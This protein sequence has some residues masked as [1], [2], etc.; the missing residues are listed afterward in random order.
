MASDGSDDA[1]SESTGSDAPSTRFLRIQAL[2]LALAGTT[3]LDDVLDV[4]VDR[5]IAAVGAR[6]GLVLL[7]AD[8]TGRLEI[9]RSTGY[10]DAI[11]PGYSVGIPRENLPPWR[12]IDTDRP[13]V[14]RVA[15]DADHYPEICATESGLGHATL[16]SVPVT[17]GSTPLGALCLSFDDSV[18]IT[19]SEVEL[20]EA[21][22]RHCGAAVERSSLLAAE[23]EAREALDAARDQAEVARDRLAFLVQV[24]RTVLG[25]LD[26]TE[27]LERVLRHAVPRIADAG[28]ALLPTR[29]GLERVAV[30]HGNPDVEA[31]G[32]EYLLGTVVGFDAD[33]PTAQCFRTGEV[34]IHRDLGDGATSQAPTSDVPRRD[35]PAGLQ[36]GLIQN[37]LTNWLCV[38]IRTSSDTL[39]VLA[40]A[41]T[42]RDPLDDPEHIDLTVE[43][44]SRAAAGLVNATLYETQRGVASA[45]TTSVL[46]AVLPSVDGLDLAARYLPSGADVGGDWYDALVLEDGRVALTIGDVSGHGLSSGATMGQLRNAVR[47]YVLDGHDPAAVLERLNRLLL[48]TSHDHV[49]SVVH[50]VVDPATGAIGWAA[51]GHPP[52][53]VVDGDGARTLH[54]RSG[55]LL[56]A[57]PEALYVTEQLDLAIGAA[58]V[59]YTDGLVER[60]DEPIDQSIER[61]VGVLRGAAVASADQLCDRALAI[62]GRSQLLDDVCLLVTRRTASS[63]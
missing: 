47:A 16:I 28:M 42:T 58:L 15:D 27:V 45:L 24:G 51:A 3:S 20:F 60:R 38:P 5:G 46:P 13:V 43:L 41:W 34:V 52:S 59:L 14:V 63:M 48:H 25:S 33:A 22:G 12:A 37:S 26:R 53:I 54:G 21:V 35:V 56:G 57:T 18:A 62:E 31:L 49:A 39:A 61:L 23:R 44:A 40:L 50:A 4:T 7:F 17:A 30:A 19:D 9:V 10:G 29:D 36:Q 2:T 32:R 6:A 1:T 11:Q 8:G 55:P